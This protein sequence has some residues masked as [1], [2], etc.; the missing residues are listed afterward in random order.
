MIKNTKYETRDKDNGFQNDTTQ[1]KDVREPL[2]ININS[3]MH[4]TNMESLQFTTSVAENNKSEL[5]H[6]RI[7][8]PVNKT[9][10][11]LEFTFSTSQE[12][13]GTGCCKK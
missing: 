4:T 2:L 7:T 5:V 1:E 3:H 8:S 10:A 11:P 9:G 6:E 13:G 12:L